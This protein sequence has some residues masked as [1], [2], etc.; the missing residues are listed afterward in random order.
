MGESR[1]ESGQSGVEGETG[2]TNSRLRA[3][4]AQV[5]A[6]ALGLGS[7]EEVAAGLRPWV[8]QAKD[9]GC[10]LLLFPLLPVFPPSVAMTL[11]E[12]AGFFVA[13]G[14]AGEAFLAAPD[15]SVLGRQAQTQVPPHDRAAGQV[16]GQALEPFSLPPPAPTGLKAGFLVGPDAWYPE[17][18]RILTLKG[19]S[20]LLAPEAMPAPYNPWFQVAGVWQEV[21]QNQVFGLEACLVG[22]GRE[23]S[24]CAGRSGIFAPCEMT[25]GETG[26]LGQIGVDETRLDP[27]QWADGLS[28]DG[29]DRPG[30]VVADL[31]F[32]ALQGTVDAY[33]LWAQQNSDFYH[34][35][36]PGVYG[37]GRVGGGRP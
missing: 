12:E 24:T 29:S 21:Q 23:T 37:S 6:E 26:I 1:A 8:T 4:V 32:A 5:P 16:P 31:D 7:P 22:K 35:F 20:L 10:Q 11:A 14:G 34:A 13:G 3:G 33:S 2:L 15:G 25:R 17:V 9:R 18:A 30:L 36:F 28:V 19:A 27:G